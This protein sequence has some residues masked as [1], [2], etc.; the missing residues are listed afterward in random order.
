MVDFHDNNDEAAF[1][2]QVRSFI[3]DEFLPRRHRMREEARAAQPF[4]RPPTQRE[5]EKE[6]ANRGW[7][8]PAWPEQYGG[9][10]LSIMQQFIFNEEMAEARAPRPGGIAI[11]MVGP[12]LITIGTEEQQQEHLPPI[13]SGDTI[14][15]QGYSEPGSG[16]DLASLQTRAVK[17]GDDFIVNGQKI[18]TSGAHKSDWMILLAR[19]DPDAPKHKGITYFVLDMHSPGVSTRPLVNMAGTHEFNEVFF[20]DVRIPQRNVLGEVNRGWYGAVTT[21]DFE[22][23]SIGSAVGMQQ[24]VQDIIRYAKENRGTGLSSVDRR[25]TKLA[26][27][28]RYIETQTARMI[29]YRIVSMQNQGLIPNHEASMAKLFAMELNQR[30]TATAV[31]VL[32]LHGQ[33]QGRNA[34]RRGRHAYGFI[35]SIANTIEGGTSEIQRNIIAT[36][37]LGLPR[38]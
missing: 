22:R 32:G 26:L 19:T 18:W 8:A 38:G 16:S 23:S 35:R 10:G 7:I 3:A 13:L 5:W 6:L 30:I 34:P 21:L 11:G 1:R 20:E 28:D 14:W 4:D 27:T 33:L 12:T 37:G 9:A 36:R 29:S 24:S 31:K 15:C 2:T 25:E 17:D